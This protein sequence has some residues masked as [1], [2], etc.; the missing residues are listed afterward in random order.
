MGRGLTVV[1]AK[2]LG[3]NLTVATSHLESPIPSSNQWF[4]KER[5]EQHQFAIKTLD[6]MAGDGQDVLMGGDFNWTDEREGP[7]EMTPGWRDAWMD[8]MLEKSVGGR[9]GQADTDG[10]TYDA[11]VN[12]MLWG[13]LRL[14]LD[15]FIARLGRSFELKGIEMVGREPI[16][17]VVF[18]ERGQKK[19]VYASDHFGLLLTIELKEGV[20]PQATAAARGSVGGG[21]GGGKD[22]EGEGGDGRVLVPF[23]GTARRLG[24]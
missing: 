19:P 14:R 9:G 20:E 4:S 21:S 6:A 15:R 17:G 1:R 2:V 7:M 5:K 22:R 18:M 12:K 13:G 3:H 23:S 8:L 11:K 10:Y 24:D 16:E